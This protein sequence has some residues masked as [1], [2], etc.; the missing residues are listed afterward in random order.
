MEC[1]F[2]KYSIEMTYFCHILSHRQKGNMKLYLILL[3]I[4]GSI[5][6][7]FA[8]AGGPGFLGGLG[9][10]PV[11]S[12]VSGDHASGPDKFGWHATLFV[13][14]PL[15]VNRFLSFELLYIQKGSRAF[16]D[17]ADS[18][19][20]SFRDYKLNL[21]YV[22]FPV[23][24]YWQPEAFAAKEYF[25]RLWFGAGGSLAI[26]TGHYEEDGGLDITER[27]AEARPFRP[28]ELNLMGGVSYHLSDQWVLSLRI[29]QGVT[30]FRK[31]GTEG[32]DSRYWWNWHNQFGQYHTAWSFGVRYAFPFPSQMR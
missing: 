9:T 26:L 18:G 15:S 24:M 1:I 11:F 8:L 17:P 23:V 22:E 27:E 5:F 14:Y 28:L 16:N 3:I 31:H 4:F 12:E 30:P 19:R 6:P 2:Y 20:G 21:H 7:A 29:H 13:A 32:G 25:D 10:G